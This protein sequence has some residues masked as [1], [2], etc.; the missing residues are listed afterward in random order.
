M[1]ETSRDA[2]SNVLGRHYVVLIFADLSQSTEL[3]AALEAEHYA[4]L[5]AAVRQAY[6]DTIPK[7]GGLVVRVQGDGVLAMFGYPATREDDGRRAVEAALQLHARVRDTQLE[8]PAG[9]ALSLHT[10]IHS[11]LVLIGVGDI[12]R[13]RYELLGSVPNVAARLSAAATAN[14]ILVS[15][16][17][18][19]PARRFFDIGMA[20][21]LQIKGQAAPITVYAVTGKAGLA[22]RLDNRA[23]YRVAPFVGRRAEHELLNARLTDA[24]AGHAHCVA[25]AAP[26]GMG[27]TRLV[28]QVLASAEAQD[29]RVLR[30]YCESYLGAEPLQPFVQ[31]LQALSE[32]MP[33]KPV[34]GLCELFAGLATQTPL[35]L[36]IDDWQWADD[37]SKQ[38]LASLRK[39]T[40]CRQLI[41]LATRDAEP[42]AFPIAGETIVLAPLGDLEA[43]QAI[44]AR[45]PAVDPFVAA[46][47]AHRAGG[48]PL[49]IEELCHSMARGDSGPTGRSR[50]SAGWLS[51]LVESRVEHLPP[52]QIKLV[53]VAAVIGNVIAIWLFESLTNTSANSVLVRGLAEQ[54]FIFPGEQA[55]TL[56]FKHGVTRDIIYESVG[57]LERQQLHLHIAR[58]IQRQSAATEQDEALEALAYHFGAGG[59]A[60]NAARYAELAG[61]KAMHASALD[62]TRAQ[63]R[64]A[65]AALDRLPA[66]PEVAQRWVSIVQRLGMVCVFDPSRSELALSTRALHLAEQFADEATVVRAR[67]WHSYISYSLGDARS[68][69][70][71][72]ERA[73]VEAEAIGDEPLATQ[74]VATLGESKVL[75]AHYDAGLKL[76]DRAI[77]VK[78]RYRSGRHTNVGLVYSLVCRAYV[79]GDRGLFAQAHECFEEA[80]ACIV[81]VTHEIRATV[82]G[83]RSAVLL[84]QGRWADARKAAIESGH[85]AEATRSLSQLSIARAMAGYAQWKLEQSPEAVQAIVEATDWLAPRE[86]GLFRSLNHGWLAEG[87]MAVGRREEAR[88][89]AALALK[90]ARERDLI[91]VAMTYRALARDAAMHQ[92][93]A[94]QR[95]IELALRTARERDSAHEIAVTRLCAAQ[96]ALAQ[97]RVKQAT[98]LIDEASAAFDAM[99]MTWHLE[100][101]TR[102][103]ALAH[104]VAA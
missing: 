68:A 57:L 37:G 71:H 65:L 97:G 82:H 12:E 86:S 10:G 58:A 87:L 34:E 53:R 29:C 60:A 63:Y 27:K 78:R 6:Q 70:T 38:V 28:E 9:V 103:R 76:L 11:G 72:G 73:L 35:V 8:L 16:E 19:G 75:A 23:R 96:I 99:L 51:H 36:F 46:E 4:Q 98:A 92:A 25:I 2:E 52:A 54:D 13:G 39:L 64:A 31:M 77:E 33:A 49:F 24:V 100:E 67:Y 32:A 80:L 102:L 20:R 85:I 74:I 56:R 50:T 1:S 5:L 91:G 42:S 81:D 26:A 90:R 69:I 88:R 7:H 48:N 66:S 44:A 93:E 59:D 47:I 104:R 62:R 94:A 45:L 15:E 89:N 14:E 55:G 22:E 18:L 17:T 95:Y 40:N 41:I 79:L 43:G 83:W 101:A 3:A 21:S 84:W 30:G 61:D